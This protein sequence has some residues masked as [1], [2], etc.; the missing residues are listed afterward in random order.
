MKKAKKILA[1]VL[2]A[3]LLMSLTVVGTLAYLT[4]STGEVK[5][6]FTVGQVTINLDEAKVTEYGVKDGDTRVKANTYKLIPGHEYLKDPKV[7]VESGSEQCYVFIKVVDEIAAIED[8]AKAHVAE[9]IAINLVAQTFDLTL[10]KKEFK[11]LTDDN[12]TYDYYK[13]VYY[14]D[15]FETIFQFDKL[16]DELIKSEEVEDGI[17]TLISYKNDY[18]GTVK[19]VEELTKDAV[20][21]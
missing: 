2:S 12:Y 3:L 5:N 20:T 13:D 7:Y 17:A 11:E 8:A 9:T 18:I 15:S 19:R 16:M 1:L 10:S 6:T 14:E 4:A 21:E